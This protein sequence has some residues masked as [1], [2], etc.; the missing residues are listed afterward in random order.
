MKT[1]KEYLE[2]ITYVSE[3]ER[4]GQLKKALKSN[5]DKIANRV[6]DSIHKDGPDSK[7]FKHAQNLVKKSADFGG[8]RL[9]KRVNS[10]K[11]KKNETRVKREKEQLQVKTGFSYPRVNTKGKLTKTATKAAK[12]FYKDK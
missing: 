10:D 11:L 1:F 5:D 2:E 6:A 7:S 3:D 4:V 12:D 9:K 8:S